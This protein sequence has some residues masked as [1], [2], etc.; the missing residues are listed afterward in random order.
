MKKII[1]LVV[2]FLGL[3]VV[4]TVHAVPAHP[5][6]CPLWQPDG[7][8]HLCPDGLAGLALAQGVAQCQT[9]RWVFVAGGLPHRVGQA[10]GLGSAGAGTVV[11]NVAAVDRI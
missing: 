1:G 5:P 10:L 7:P 4:P 9:C 2:L 6:L 3:S 11:A 8:V